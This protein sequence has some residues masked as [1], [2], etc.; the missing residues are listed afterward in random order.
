MAEKVHEQMV[1][2]TRQEIKEAFIE[3]ME[4]KG[5]EGI[6]VR[7]LTAMAKIN[8][9]TFYLHYRDK[10][11]LMEKTQ[12]ELLKGFREVISHINPL[13]ALQFIPKNQTYP[14][15]IQIFEYLSQHGR[16]FKLLLGP[17]GD[18]AFPKKWKDTIK[19]YFFEKNVL[20]RIDL[21]EEMIVLREY[22]PS[23]GT[24]IQFGII[25]KWLENDMP[26]PPEEMART[27]FQIFKMIGTQINFK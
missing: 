10:Y 20:Q 7:D 11:D 3:L 24:S 14:V 13:E 27:I 22:L 16:I 23:I 9:G 17:K 1:S 6:T 21:P 18:P 25:E 15:V 19:K 26:H 8:R 12:E 4:K 5:F 2:R